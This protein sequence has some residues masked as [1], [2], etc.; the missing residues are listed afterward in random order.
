MRKAI[1]NYADPTAAATAS[2]AVTYTVNKN[3]DSNAVSEYN[4]KGLSAE[5]LKKLTTAGEVKNTP[6]AESESTKKNSGK[7]KKAIYIAVAVVAVV[8][9]IYIIRKK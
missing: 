7:S 8:A 4:V 3:A 6:A 1:K 5:Q 2:D 9:A